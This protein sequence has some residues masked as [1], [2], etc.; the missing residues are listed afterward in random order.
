MLGLIGSLALLIGICLVPTIIVYQK[1]KNRGNDPWLWTIFT[2]IGAFIIVFG[3]LFL[4][5]INIEWGR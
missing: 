5:L 2:F 4:I 1:I 3:G